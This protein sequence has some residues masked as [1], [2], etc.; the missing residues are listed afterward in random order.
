[1]THRQRFIHARE[2]RPPIPGSRV[3]HFELVFFLTMEAFGR[4]H[5]RQRHYAQWEQSR[6]D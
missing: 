1:M 4:V 6:S 2:R 3:P 5:S